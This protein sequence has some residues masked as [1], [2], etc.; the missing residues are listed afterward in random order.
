M[1]RRWGLRI[2]PSVVINALGI[3]AILH[4]HLEATVEKHVQDSAHRRTFAGVAA[5]RQEIHLGN[6]RVGVDGYDPKATK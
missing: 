6:S 3:D 5:S 4:P 2:A 1:I